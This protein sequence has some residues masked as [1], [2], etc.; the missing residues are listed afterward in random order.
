MNKRFFSSWSGGKDSCLAL[1]RAM[2]EGYI[3]QVLLT[4]FSM[5]N[6]ISSAHRL[7]EEVIR[8]QADAIGI[9][10]IIGRALFN[11]Y[12]EVFVSNIKQFK[13]QGVDYGVFGDIDL[14]EHREW[15]ERVC[16]RADITVVLPLWKESRRELVKEFINLGFKAKIVVVNTSMLDTRFLGQDLS[17][18]LMDEIEAFGADVCG[19]NG[20][21]HTLVYDG[22][23]FKKTV[24]FT[25]GTEIIPVGEKWAHITVK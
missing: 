19:E 11:D 21:Y 15:E 8:A 1:Y 2:Q 7:E 18:S 23:I 13:E 22:P 9:D 4:M 20:E 5:E 14:M 25:F 10:C 12:E 17:Y 6:G 3:P 24:E 16:N